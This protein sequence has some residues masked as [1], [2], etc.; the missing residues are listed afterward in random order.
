MSEFKDRE[1]IDGLF[2]ETEH[3]DLELAA[4]IRRKIALD[5][6]KDGMPKHTGEIRVLNEVLNSLEGQRFN[7]AN[8]RLKKQENSNKEAMAENVAAMLLEIA[9]T[10]KENQLKAPTTIVALPS[11]Y[12]P[13]D[14]V[15]G[16]T[17]IY[18][19]QLDIKDFIK[20]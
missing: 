8:T 18:S 10:K 11:D 9:R 13:V 5:M 3:N 19:D 6:T 17:T 16:E 4:N 2:T 20:E 7:M 14:I 15:P 12:V 1:P